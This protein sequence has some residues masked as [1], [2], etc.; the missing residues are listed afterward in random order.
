MRRSHLGLI[1]FTDRLGMRSTAVSVMR[2]LDE[3]CALTRPLAFRKILK[4]HFPVGGTPSF[5]PL[6]SFI[7]IMAPWNSRKKC[8][9]AR[10]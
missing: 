7:G 2:S 3:L 10:R 4:W 8:S 5:L 1:S 9:P 6:L